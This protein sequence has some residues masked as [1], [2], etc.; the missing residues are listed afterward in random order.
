MDN[1]FSSVDLFAYLHH[2]RIGAC[3]ITRSNMW[4]ISREFKN[5]I[6][7]KLGMYLY[8]W[9]YI[10][11]ES[12]KSSLPIDKEHSIYRTIWLDNNWVMLY[13]IIYELC[14]DWDGYTEVLQKYPPISITNSQVVRKVFEDKVRK[15]LLISQ[16]IDNYNQNM[17]RVNCANHL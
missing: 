5:L 7:K 13:S 8:T 3:G 12:L 9:G 2:M 4:G 16:I 1:F 17:N 15:M 11:S 14:H 10:Y 6:N